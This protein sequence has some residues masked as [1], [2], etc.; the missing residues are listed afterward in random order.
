METSKQKKRNQIVD[1]SDLS[2]VGLKQDDQGDESE[3]D[4]FVDRGNHIEGQI[5]SKT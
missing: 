5:G 3:I 2:Q 4:A 1:S